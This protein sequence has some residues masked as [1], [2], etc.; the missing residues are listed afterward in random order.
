MEAAILK[1]MSV[2]RSARFSSAAEMKARLSASAGETRAISGETAPAK[3][4]LLLLR[5]GTDQIR[6]AFQRKTSA[7]RGG[8]RV[9]APQTQMGIFCASGVYVGN[10]FPLTD[11]PLLLG[12]RN[13]CG[14]VFPPDA[15]A[16]AAYT[17][18]SAQRRGKVQCSAGRRLAFGTQIAKARC[19]TRARNRCCPSRGVYNRQ[20]ILYGRAGG[21]WA[22]LTQRTLH[23][24]QWTKRR[25]MRFDNAAYS[26]SEGRDV[27]GT[28][29]SAAA[30][31]YVLAASRTA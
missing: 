1:G 27:N 18:K 29:R 24:R 2:E 16:S 12:G 15:T 7:E 11:D 4:L 25:Q 6:G 21:D 3:S 20:R 14:I 19:C 13:R 17:A 23:G 9:V 30:G 5:Q 31:K 28:R 26:I 22:V 10:T 8:S